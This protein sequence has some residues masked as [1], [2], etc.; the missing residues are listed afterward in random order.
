MYDSTKYATSSHIESFPL[1]RQYRVENEVYGSRS[2]HLFQWFML[3]RKVCWQNIRY[4]KHSVCSL[5]F[6]HSGLIIRSR[7]RSGM[8]IPDFKSWKVLQLKQECKRL[9]LVTSRTKQGLIE[10]LREYYEKESM[11][12]NKAS[13]IDPNVIVIS[14]SELDEHSTSF[15]VVESK[16]T[17]PPVEK[18]RLSNALKSLSL[19]DHGTISTSRSRSASTCSSTSESELPTNDHASTYGP[20]PNFMDQ[21]MCDAIFADEQLFKRILM[22]E[23]IS[24]D[25]MLG[26]AHRSK[27][28]TSA[29]ATRNRAELRTWLDCQGICFYEAELST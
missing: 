22:L 11:N 1:P 19:S 18:G 15:E 20:Q 10:L 2:L 8:V 4:T 25:E 29:S 17:S 9:G 23:P 5:G 12:E 14:D 3:V 13:K 16:S 26:V 7:I 27:V 6:F 24:L 28:L 21:P